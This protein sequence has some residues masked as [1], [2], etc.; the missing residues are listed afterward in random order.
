M[1]GTWEFAP[2]W[3]MS[4]LAS[5]LFGSTGGTRQAGAGVE[6]GYAIATNLWVSAG[7]NFLGFRDDELSGAD[8]TAKGGFIRMRYKFDEALLEAGK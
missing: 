6:I 4:V 3:D 2:Q 1:R 5:G 7:Y 8:Y